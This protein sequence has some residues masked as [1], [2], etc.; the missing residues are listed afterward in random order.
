MQKQGKIIAI[1]LS[2][3]IMFLSLLV[4][5]VSFIVV[6]S[7]PSLEGSFIGR[8]LPPRGGTPGLNPLEDEGNM[9]DNQLIPDQSPNSEIN[10]E[11]HMFNVLPI[12]ILLIVITTGCISLYFKIDKYRKKNTKQNA[13]GAN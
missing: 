13:V 12:I 4:I 6:L 8:Q 2:P 9:S 5:N 10:L 7:A 3:T 1:I 11:N